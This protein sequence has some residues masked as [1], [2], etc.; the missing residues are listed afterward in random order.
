MS[1]TF[2]LARLYRGR[3]LALN[4]LDLYRVGAG[5][6]GD[7]GI[8]DFIHD[9]KA[10]C[11]IEWPEAGAAYYPKDRLEVRL[12]HV[13]SGRRLAFKALGRRSRELLG[14]LEAK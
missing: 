1:P 8:E 4:H 11:V 5:E 2:G 3:R 12:S 13:S 14:R 7:I 9:P 6:T 10:A